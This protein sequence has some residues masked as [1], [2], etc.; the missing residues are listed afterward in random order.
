MDDR[1]IQFERDK[2]C[3]EQNCEAFRALNQFMWQVPVIAM[4]LTGGLWYGV[5]TLNEMKGVIKALLLMLAALGDLAFIVVLVRVRAV[6]GTYLERIKEFNPGSCAVATYSGSFW[7]FLRSELTS[8]KGNKVVV[9][10]FSAL[11]ALAAVGSLLA[12]CLGV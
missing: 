6:M 8:S 2:I 5:A 11:L 1:E 12:L 7:S 9:R 3:Y 4:T 10:T